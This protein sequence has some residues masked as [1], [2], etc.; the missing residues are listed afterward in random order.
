MGNSTGRCSTR[1][2]DLASH[3]TETGPLEMSVPPFFLAKTRAIAG[4]AEALLPEKKSTSVFL[5]S[6]TLLYKYFGA[7]PGLAVSQTFPRRPAYFRGAA[8]SGPSLKRDASYTPRGENATRA[9]RPSA[10]KTRRERHAPKKAQPAFPV[11]IRG[12]YAMVPRRPG[13]GCPAC[14]CSR[15]TRHQESPVPI[16][17]AGG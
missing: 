17:R 15:Q 7:G 10:A 11:A 13:V 1:S 8:G 16:H 3:V 2:N 12:R 6:C 14:R 5:L 9:T 4:R